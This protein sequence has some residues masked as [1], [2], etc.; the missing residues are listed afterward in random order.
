MPK[1]GPEVGPNRVH[2]GG[3]K[4]DF[5]PSTPTKVMEN[6][7]LKGAPRDPR[8]ERFFEGFE[9]FYYHHYECYYQQSL[10]LL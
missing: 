6:R 5:R 9:Y 2:S 3:R 7:G 10:L 4:F 1:G 8:G